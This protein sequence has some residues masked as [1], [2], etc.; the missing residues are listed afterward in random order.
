MAAFRYP[1]LAAGLRTARISVSHAMRTLSAR[2]SLLSPLAQPSRAKFPR[3]ISLV[4]GAYK[5]EMKEFWL[6]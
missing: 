6:T 4:S 1:I 5:F 2:I 3:P